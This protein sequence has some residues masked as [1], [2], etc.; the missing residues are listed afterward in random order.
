VTVL[1][2]FHSSHTHTFLSLLGQYV[3]V[4]VAGGDDGVGAS[5]VAAADISS[6]PLR[7]LS[8]TV[9]NVL[10]FLEEFCKFSHTPRSVVD[11]IVP[12]YLFDRFPH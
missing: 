5:V 10:L 3:R 9:R 1:N 8:A 2:Q 11:A 4:A 6:A 7:P 12:S